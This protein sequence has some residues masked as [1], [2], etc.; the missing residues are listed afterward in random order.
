M[1]FQCVLHPS[2]IILVEHELQL[3]TYF[4]IKW[5]F[6]CKFVKIIFFKLFFNHSG[7]V[8]TLSKG[9]EN[10]L[11]KTCIFFSFSFF[12]LLLLFIFFCILAGNLG[13]LGFTI[14]RH[15]FLPL[16]ITFFSG[17]TDCHQPRPLLFSF[18]DGY[19]RCVNVMLKHVSQCFA[20]AIPRA[21]NRVM[22]LTLSHPLNFH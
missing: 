17:P 16:K 7:M 5:Y 4:D 14:S 11:Q 21:Q 19:N 18:Q 8:L 10:T 13:F 15:V 3:L 1:V 9:P 12:F 6:F 22:S 20:V 2:K